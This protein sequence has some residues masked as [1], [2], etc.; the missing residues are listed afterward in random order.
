[1]AN[2]IADRLTWAVEI[3]AVDPS[4]R[5]LEIGCGYGTAVSLISERLNGG[6]IVAIDQSDKM[7]R[8]AEKLN[9]H[10]RTAGIASF[11]AAPLHEADLGQG[12]FNK[13]FAVNVNLFWMKAARELDIIRDR[14]LP[15]GALYLFNQ[16]PVP[17]KLRHIAD[18]TSSNLADAG[19]AV[20]R[21][22]TGD[23]SPVPVVCVIAERKE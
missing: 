6:S 5:I 7:I 13:I 4:D 10:N 8:A 14:L 21:I 23:Q 16:P 2:A 9:E 22:V 11:I 12:R 15:E 20:K 1:M 3:L 18:R 17:D 19:F